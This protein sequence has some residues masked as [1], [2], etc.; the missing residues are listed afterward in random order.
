MDA[1]TGS[2]W[3]KFAYCRILLLI[4]SVFRAISF[5]SVDIWENVYRKTSFRLTIEDHHVCGK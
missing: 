4:T 5:R 1:K 3:V 2:V